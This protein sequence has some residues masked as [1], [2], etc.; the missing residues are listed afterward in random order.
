MCGQSRS[1]GAP[2]PRSVALAWLLLLALAV[3]APGIG[4]RDPAPP[5]EPR[6]ALAARTMW[7]SGKWLLPQ[8]GSELYAHKPPL[9]MWLQAGSYGLVRD[10][11]VAFLLPSLLAALATLGLVHDLGRRLWC[12][13][14]GR[15]AALALLVT[16]QFGL[17]A[18]RGQIDMVLVA[19]TTLSLWALLRHLLVRRSP[20][21][22]LLAGV[23][24]GL[25]TVTK[26][27]GFL[28]LLSLLP[29]WWSGRG[30]PAVPPVRG[31]LLALGFAGGCLVWLGPLLATAIG[32]A[33]PALAAY[34]D[35]ILLRQT[36]QRYAD[37]WHHLR[38]AWYYLPVIA[39]LWLPG[40]LLL[41]WLL[42]AWRR[43]WRRGDAR[44]VVLLGWAALVLL[45]L[46]ASPGKREVYILPA[47]PA[48]C[49][50][51]APLLPGLLPRHPVRLALR[52]YLLALAL[53]L[54]GMG[55]GMLL[56][57]GG[58][59]ERVASG[60]GLSIGDLRQLGWAL[61]ATGA[62]A[63]LAVAGTRRRIGHGL[64][65]AT[66]VLWLGHGLGMAPALD[67][68]SSGRGLMEA[69]RARLPAGAELGL[70]AW[71]EQLLL[72]APAGTVDFGFE[73]P[74]P[75]QWQAAAA[76]QGAAPERRWLLSDR[77][78]LDPCVAPGRSVAVG[79]ANRR[80]WV[81][82]PASAWRDACA[83]GTDAGRHATEHSRS[84]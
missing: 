16:L 40:V 38:P 27:V 51:A 32:S 9:F 67:A 56:D 78:A 14:V 24:A 61:V 41:P 63:G 42:P 18:R 52:G 74:W 33:D 1:R 70:V 57:L 2:P 43:R 60:R 6:F 15:H 17:Q 13:R 48:L 12:P 84:G 50:A 49:L 7:D 76:W 72:Q 35:E 8:R 71:T 44:M 58:L 79:R 68:S 73:R 23:A 10:W 65:A 81:L 4:L 46:S 69:A 83:P 29:W 45:F 26:G 62:C 77:E 25:G 36:A 30:R 53:L 39:T 31:G 21:L 80:E 3:L 55:A 11:Q 34:L 5:D 75:L 47:L 20:G 37:P 82:L 64:V 59:G 19:M 28:P 22:A 54:L 66:A